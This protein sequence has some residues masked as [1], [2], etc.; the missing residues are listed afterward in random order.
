MEATMSLAR[1]FQR[2]RSRSKKIPP[3]RKKVYFEP[4][5]PR[6]L[7]SDFTYAPAAGAALDATLRLHE[8]DDGD[9][10]Q[11]IDNTADQ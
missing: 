9:T 7:L 3:P 4:L 2:F 1:S 8:A 11:L 6:V 10:L 5:E